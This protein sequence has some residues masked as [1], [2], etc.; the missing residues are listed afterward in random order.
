VPRTRLSD[1][2]PDAEAFLEASFQ[3]GESVAA[4]TEK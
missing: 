3:R 4:T 1:A 2:V